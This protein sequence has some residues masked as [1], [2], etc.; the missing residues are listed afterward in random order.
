MGVILPLPDVWLPEQTKNIEKIFSEWN[1]TNTAVSN[2]ENPT[3]E[4]STTGNRK[5]L[6]AENSNKTKLKT[7]ILISIAVLRHVRLHVLF[8][9][10]TVRKLPSALQ[11][12]VGFFAGVRAHVR[13]Q[14]ADLIE[15]FRA[16]VARVRPC[17]EVHPPVSIQARLELKSERA[18]LAEERPR[19]AVHR[20]MFL[21]LT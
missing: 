4:F 16:E 3:P 19:V 12:Q 21:H 15:L 8:Q 20:K 11:A 10:W 13:L 5:K 6:T 18:D 1:F 7:S 17:R 9:R 2:H 14:I